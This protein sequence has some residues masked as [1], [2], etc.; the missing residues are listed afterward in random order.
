MTR[1]TWRKAVN[2]VMLTSTGL[3]A[4]VAVSVLF[5]ILGYLLWYGWRSLS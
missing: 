5:F 2:A 4:L 3:C 1:Y